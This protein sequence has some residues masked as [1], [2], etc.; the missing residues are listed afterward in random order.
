MRDYWEKGEPALSKNRKANDLELRLHLR[1]TWKYKKPRSFGAAGLEIRN[2]KGNLSVDD[3]NQLLLAV[4]AVVE[5][6]SVWIFDG[7]IRFV[8]ADNPTI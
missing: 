2:S 8:F 5:G 7:L 4:L 1:L 6:D 3:R